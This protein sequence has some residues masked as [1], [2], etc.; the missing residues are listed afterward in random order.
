MMRLA[1]GVLALILVPGT[2]CSSAAEPDE[3]A[4][5]RTSGPTA[6]G[7]SSASADPTS[8]GTSSSAPRNAHKAVKLKITRVA[9]GLDHPWDVHPIG[10]GRLLVTERSGSLT[11][12]E[13]GGAVRRLQ[14]PTDLIWASG[15][16]GLMGL[17]ID[18][19]FADNRRVYTCNG[20]L[21]QGAHDVRIMVWKLNAAAT[22]ATYKRTILS[23]FPTSSRRHG[24][25]RLLILDN[26]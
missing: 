19:K 13:K 7:T 9:K 4:A 8:S 3:P 18:P 2:A 23:G 24:G 20:G 12:I 25:C 11:V 17:A 10:H 22:R 6:N 5:G 26:G 14:M 15:E 1:A 16:T 21:P